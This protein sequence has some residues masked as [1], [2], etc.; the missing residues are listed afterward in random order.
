MLFNHLIL[1]DIIYFPSR[2]Q[3]DDKT[4]VFGIVEK[5]CMVA[6]LSFTIA[7]ALKDD[8]LHIVVQRGG[9]VR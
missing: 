5:S 2:I 1:K 7:V 3:V 4:T 9:S 8:S 6:V